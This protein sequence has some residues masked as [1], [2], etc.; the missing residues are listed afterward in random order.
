MLTNDAQSSANSDFGRMCCP[1]KSSLRNFD[2]TMKFTVS[3]LLRRTSRAAAVSNKISEYMRME[4]A[5]GV[6]YRSRYLM[7]TVW[8]GLATIR[9]NDKAIPYRSSEYEIRNSHF[10]YSD[11]G[12]IFFCVVP[13]QT[14]QVRDTDYINISCLV[15]SICC[16]V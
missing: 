6:G 7:Y 9:G 2:G 8:A 12:V 5:L 16:K 1:Q 3:Q 4:G 15:S 14:T 10:P 11:P 13:L